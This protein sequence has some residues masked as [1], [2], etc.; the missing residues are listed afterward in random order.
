MWNLHHGF[1]MIKSRRMKMA[2][3]VGYMREIRTA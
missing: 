3:H 2:E 1:R